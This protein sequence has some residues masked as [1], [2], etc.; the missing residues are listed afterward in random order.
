MQQF[1]NDLHRS[2]LWR[3]AAMVLCALV[4]AG[5]GVVPIPD[6]TAPTPT[7]AV[8]AGVDPAPSATTTPTG[9]ALPTRT[10]A[11]TVTSTPTLLP[12]STTL[13]DASDPA[14]FAGAPNVRVSRGQ[15][16]AHSEVTLAQNPADP[17][18]LIGGSKMFTDNQ[19]YIFRIG[20]YASFDGGKSWIDNGQLPGLEEYQVTS[21]PTVV[22][23]NDGTAY[24]EVLAARD[25]QQRSALYVY[26]STDGGRTWSEPLLVSN[27]SGGF[28]DKN[29]LAADTSGAAN[30]GNLYTTWVQIADETYSVKFSRSTDGGATW[31]QPVDLAAE[32]GVT[33]QGQVVSVDAAGTVFVLWNNL[34]TNRFEV[35]ASTDGGATWSA[36]RQGPAHQR[37]APL[38][39]NL[40]RSF[41]LPAFTAD[42]ATAGTLY[43][44][45]D[46]GRLG[47]SD[48]LYSMSTD[49]GQTW[50]PPVVINGI[51]T[52]DQFQPW[53]AANEESEIFVQWF[54]RRGDPANLRVHTYAARSIDG[55]KTWSEVRVTDVASD[56][57]VGLPRAGEAGFYGDYQALVADE[58]GTHLFWNETRDGS[59]EVYTTRL[60]D[61]RW[62]QPFQADP[63]GPPAPQPPG[64]H[65]TEEEEAGE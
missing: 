16:A 34:T 46:D 1:L 10:A 27:D 57:T 4:V 45:W 41:V 62:P 5:C 52:N 59:Q 47:N 24:I 28:N 33:R 56:P 15:F 60:S 31:S 30:D 6:A 22:F 8:A 12:T 65:E 36:I 63:V 53:V 38:N 44:V 9:T 42:P 51:T 19:N 61:D 55:G 13:A 49:N 2:R 11:P 37:V 23:T 50:Q 54:D 58:S 26:K 18:N 25:A 14:L 43:V 32:A 20:T 17:N 48:V 29:W 7:I 64:E 40:R 21:D 35:V 39:G 3:G